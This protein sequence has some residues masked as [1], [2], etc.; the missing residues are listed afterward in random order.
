MSDYR[1]NLVS[2]NL[3][4]SAL[5]GVSKTLSPTDVTTRTVLEPMVKE[6]LQASIGE[7]Y[8]ED[9]VLVYKVIVNNATFDEEYNNKLALKQQAQMTYETQQINN[10]TEIE[11][12]EAEAKAQIAKS[13]AIAE[14]SIIAAKAD[15]EVAKISADSAEYQGQKDAAIMSNLGEMLTKYPQ[16]IDYYRV[17]NWDGKLPVV[18]TGEGSGTLLDVKDIIGN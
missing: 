1:N 9:V 2:E 5:K 8:G 17:N 11:K 18:Q 4:S 3:V 13:Q 10:R 6:A 7:K 12:A 16:L 15:A 14:S